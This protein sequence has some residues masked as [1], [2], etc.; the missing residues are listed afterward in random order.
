MQNFQDM[1]LKWIRTYREILKSASAYLSVT[2]TCFFFYKKMNF[3]DPK[4]LRRCR[5]NLQPQMAGLQFL[6]TSIF[7]RALYSYKIE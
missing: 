3:K 5:E 2:N 1:I 6:I 4:T 7:P